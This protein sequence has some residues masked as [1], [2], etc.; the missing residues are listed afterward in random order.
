MKFLI[1]VLTNAAAIWLCTQIIPSI[2]VVTQPDQ[3][4][5]ILTFILVAIVF[6]LVNM[7]V[8]PVVVFITLPL[9]L[10][11]IGLFHFVV[12]AIML[13]LTAWVTSHTSWQL[14]LSGF[15]AAILGSLVISLVNM[16]LRPAFKA[17]KLK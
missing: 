16:L 6:T 2:Q 1:R 17:L 14:T 5:R 3:A 12:N 4:D 15:G 10:F 7:L 11:T 8:K 13:S 9:Y